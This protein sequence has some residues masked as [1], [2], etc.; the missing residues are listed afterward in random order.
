[1]PTFIQ[2]ASEALQEIADIRI[3]CFGHLGDG[4]LHFNVF[5]AKGKHKDDYKDQRAGFSRLVHD[6]VH[7]HD[8]SFSAEHGVGRL[9][10]A[11]LERYGDPVKL[12]MMRAVKT[13]LDPAGIMNP[14]VIFI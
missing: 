13:T 2:Q 5:P 12:Q 14:G 3:N 4:N 6:L 10:T 11:D 1:M 9:K 8:G 7:T